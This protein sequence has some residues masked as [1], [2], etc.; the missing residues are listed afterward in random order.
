MNEVREPQGGD[1]RDWALLAVLL[2]LW[3][4]AQVLL[5]RGTL[6]AES[7]GVTPLLQAADI[8][9]GNW[10]L[11]GWTGA[12]N[13]FCT[14]DVLLGVV[15]V[16]LFS[17]SLTAL[18]VQCLL[19]YGGIIFGALRLSRA[20]GS[21]WWISGALLFLFLGL[22][23]KLNTYWFLGLGDHALTI[24]AC[25]ISF[26]W[27]GSLGGED[28][29]WPRR[30]A[31]LGYAGVSFLALAG[32]PFYQYVGLLPIL[33]ASGL[34]AVWYRRWRALA[35][36]S[37]ASGLALVAAKILLGFLQARG[38]H[39]LELNPKY[40]ALADFDTIENNLYTYVR[41]WWILVGAGADNFLWLS[42]PGLNYTGG[43]NGDTD[44]S[45]LWLGGP[46]MAGLAAV[47]AGLRLLA[48]VAG[49]L[50]TGKL[51]LSRKPAG[52]PDAVFVDCMLVAGIGLDSAAYIFSRMPRE[53]DNVYTFH[54]LA[55][56]MAYASILVV[57]R[58][59]PGLSAR[60]RAATPRGRILA[61]AVF[62]AL[63][64]LCG[65]RI[66]A[67]S[68]RQPNAEA[69]QLADFLEARG[70]QSGYSGYW[71][72]NIIRML[73][74]EKVK[75]AALKY[76]GAGGIDPL[77]YLNNKAWYDS[78]ANFVISDPLSAD[79]AAEVPAAQTF[80]PPSEIK[81]IGPYHVLIWNH[82]IQPVLM[83]P[84]SP[85]QLTLDLLKLRRQTLAPGAKLNADNSI[86]DE[87]QHPQSTPIIYGPYLHLRAGHYQVSFVFATD[88]VAGT[89]SIIC[90][91]AIRNGG[92]ILAR[93]EIS[94]NLLVGRTTTS[95]VTLSFDSS[96]WEETY[97]FRVWKA[98]GAK[99][100]LQSLILVK[101]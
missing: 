40:Q 39:V 27:A 8:L 59:G 42:G 101:V 85:R 100:A 25:L 95:T 77:A 5:T 10:T 93:K 63:L 46:G 23:T 50:W 87:E 65:P 13:N 57:R 69:I 74:A 81:R 86:L 96:G 90:D 38:F 92:Q 36:F 54:Y 4:V 83:H 24:A 91:T 33:A 21:A 70:L 78:P 68:Q 22:L 62:F 99:L 30:V 71:E 64:V 49:V 48:V 53:V 26:S 43:V 15:C 58:C 88:G 29:W 14:L 51:L 80:G 94:G 37:V 11:S 75:V 3:A 55:P 35:K 1:G 45:L 73:S 76:D 17:L 9:R 97:E 31:W 82:D 44:A 84:S 72:S 7:D 20:P 18:L 6:V 19:T 34:M 47:L 52:N 89:D 41:S 12:A 98:G 2:G 67:L 60:W 28:G 32:D 61:P 66:W 79:L 16:G 56:A